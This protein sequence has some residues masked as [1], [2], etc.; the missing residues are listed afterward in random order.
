MA[1]DGAFVFFFAVVPAAIVFYQLRKDHTMHLC[2]ITG[3]PEMIDD[4]FL[5][6]PNHWREVSP[7]TKREVNDRWRQLRTTRSTEGSIAAIAAYRAAKQ[8][9]IDEVGG[10]STPALL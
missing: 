7:T 2:A 4:R 1:I 3:C 10:F 6:C 5:M 8:K 9:A